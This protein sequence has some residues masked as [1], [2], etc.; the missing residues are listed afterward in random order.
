MNFRLDRS[1]VTEE[2]LQQLVAVES[3]DGYTEEK[4]KDLKDDFKRYSI[5]NSR[6]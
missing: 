5:N 4:L 3:E 2:I 1:E 6:Y